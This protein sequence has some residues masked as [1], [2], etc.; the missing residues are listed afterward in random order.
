[1]QEIIRR[2][3]CVTYCDAVEDEISA[4][5]IAGSMRHRRPLVKNRHCHCSNDE[6]VDLW[7]SPQPSAGSRMNHNNQCTTAMVDVGKG[8]NTNTISIAR[9]TSVLPSPSPS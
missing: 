2:W 4:L 5:N 7:P 6:W 1:M 8:Q 3:C 9:G